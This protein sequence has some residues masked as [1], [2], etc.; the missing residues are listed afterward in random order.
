LSSFL[1]YDGTFGNCRVFSIVPI[2]MYAQVWFP[3]STSVGSEPHIISDPGNLMRSSAFLGY[4]MYKWCKD[5]YVT[6]YCEKGFFIC[7]CVCV[8]TPKCTYV[9]CMCICMC[10][11]IYTH[12]YIASYICT[13]LIFLKIYLF[14][15]LYNTLLLS[16]WAGA[17][18]RP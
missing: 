14:F 8:C 11:C 17:L 16:V 2:L 13:V 1:H 9:R 10:I 7:V 3:A 6:P 4:K 12:T 15:S 5:I 18:S